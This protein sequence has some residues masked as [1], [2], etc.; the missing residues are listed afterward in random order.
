MS[1][2]CHENI[3][4]ANNSDSSIADQI[5]GLQILDD[6]MVMHKRKKNRNRSTCVSGNE[7]DGAVGTH[8][9]VIM[10]PEIS[11]YNDSIDHRF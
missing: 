7:R 2:E 6:H 5:R 10:S 8:I 9:K 4:D 1:P 3:N 11:I